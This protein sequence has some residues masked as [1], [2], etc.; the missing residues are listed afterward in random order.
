MHVNKYTER[1]GRGR[2]QN[3]YQVVVENAHLFFLLKSTH[4]KFTF[5]PFLCATTATTIAHQPGQCGG[6]LEQSRS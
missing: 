4:P 2:E 1:K 5:F 6:V 3:A